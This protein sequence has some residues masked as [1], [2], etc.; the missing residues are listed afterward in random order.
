VQNFI[1]G[2]FSYDGTKAVISFGDPQ[3]PQTS[4]F[5]VATET[6]TPLPTGLVSP[7]WSPAD[8]RLAYLATGANGTE[9]LTTLDVSKATNKP[10]TL[11]TL[12]ASDLTIAWLNKNQI[13]LSD[14]P[15]AYVPSSAWLYDLTK[16]TLTPLVMEEPGLE[17]AWSGT[18]VGSSSPMG[19][20]FAAGNTA[21]GG[22]L[23][24]V[25][26]SGNAV[27]NLTLETLPSKC[28]F[29]SQ[30][31]TP[32][33]AASE[34][35]AST[36]ATSTTVTSQPSSYLA[37]F[38]AVPTNEAAF[39]GSRLPDAYNQGA[40]FTQDN[41]YE[42]TIATGAITPVFTQS[43]T[44]L[45]ARDLKIFNNVLFFVNRYDN[46]LYAISLSGV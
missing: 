7:V 15:S 1:A 29:A 30:T 43:P 28:L 25:D 27:T 2:G 16:G 18:P 5:D 36:T 35:T 13:V 21:V 42:V 4:V 19:L 26:L 17:T 44:P 20:V 24:L 9:S 32:P 14:K 8:Y 38:C 34:T 12:H 22:S 33:A 10:V 39:V 40:L 45:D 3:N 31:S 11:L 6:W 46:K 41:F 23:S 37:L